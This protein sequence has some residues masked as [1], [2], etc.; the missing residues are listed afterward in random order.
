MKTLEKDD[1]ARLIKSVF[2][3]LPGD[4]RLGVLVDVPRKK[5]TD[6]P[7]WKKR[8]SLAGEW[9]SLLGAAAG[10]I[11]LEGIGLIAYPD[12][13]SNNADLPA[14]A[15]EID[16]APPDGADGLASSGRE[17]PFAEIFKRYQLFLAPTEFSTTA[18]LKIAAKEHGFRAATM[19]GFS[20]KMLP[21]LKLDYDEVSRRVR[22]LQERLDRAETARISFLVDGE[23]NFRMTFDLRHRTSHVSSG[24]FP[25]KGTAGNLPSGE[26]YI[27]PY[28]GE[29]GEPSRTEGVLPVQIGLEIVLF[30]I[31]ENQAVY[32][33]GEGEAD[34]D[35]M[36][37]I[38]REPAYGNMAELGFGV[39]GDMGLRPIGE[40]L[41]DEK[42]GLHVAFG[43]SDHFGGAVGPKNFSAPSEVI[44]LDRIYIPAVQ[45][46]ISVESLSL[47]YKDA[48][49]ET[50]I[51]K[52][53]Y[54]IW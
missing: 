49:P 17:V 7:D 23:F 46:R 43:R 31:Q 12:V 28:E 47:E 9:A 24:R 4:K 29:R 11:P 48:A 38:M 32:V 42:L 14:T 15:Y 16:G 53:R 33:D 10:D 20:E 5:A 6:N 26:T 52:D 22:L 13:G 18:P 51:E 8:R 35:E 2:P 50:V 30:L 44:H 1:L 34:A 19:P 37:H 36:N 45:P 27:V 41:L 39:L 54:T 3:A 21:A 25:D 40:M